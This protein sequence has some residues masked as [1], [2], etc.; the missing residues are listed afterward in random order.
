MNTT[1]TNS[2]GDEFQ[3]KPPIGAHSMAKKILSAENIEEPAPPTYKNSLGVETELY[4]EL[5]DTEEL[6]Q[7]YRAY[8]KTKDE[9]AAEFAFAYYRAAVE[10]GFFPLNPFPEE[11]RETFSKRYVGVPE[12]ESDHEWAWQWL[13][14]EV[15]H[16][17]DFGKLITA[18][19]DL[20]GGLADAVVGSIKFR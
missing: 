8:V 15:A 18:L 1:W 3:I 7:I 9:Y 12:P 19:R 5:A 17:E 13:T 16:A 14:F 11:F 4:E 2:N 10:L 20:G 6:K